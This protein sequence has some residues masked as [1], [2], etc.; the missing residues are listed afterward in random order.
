MTTGFPYPLLADDVARS[1]I[2]RVIAGSE[3]TLT[4]TRM[5]RFA[6]LH[7]GIAFL[8]STVII[9]ILVTVLLAAVG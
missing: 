1:R 5:R 3:V 9:A 7:G 6:T 2:C 4:T 8:F